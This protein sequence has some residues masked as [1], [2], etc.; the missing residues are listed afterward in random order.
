MFKAAKFPDS[1]ITYVK[2]RK[3]KFATYTIINTAFT[4]CGL[5]E[6]QIILDGDDELVGK[7]VFTLINAGYQKHP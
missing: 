2:N 5:D 4:F 6:V 7:Q 3:R 1:R